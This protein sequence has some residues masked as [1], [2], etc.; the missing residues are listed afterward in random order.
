MGWEWEGILLL[1]CF[2]ML[3]FFQAQLTCS[4]WAEKGDDEMEDGGGCLPQQYDTQ[5]QSPFG[6]P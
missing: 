6:H 5:V 4:D 1:W 2:S 3:A